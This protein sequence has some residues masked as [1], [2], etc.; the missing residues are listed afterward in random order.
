MA[1][2]LLLPGGTKV[3]G[4]TRR[5]RRSRQTAKSLSVWLEMANTRSSRGKALS[6][7]KENLAPFREDIRDYVVREQAEMGARFGEMVGE[8][9]RMGV[10]PGGTEMD[11]PVAG[12]EG[13]GLGLFQG[14]G[15]GGLRGFGGRA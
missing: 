11:Q 10:L 15:A 13:D 5:L 1:V 3:R 7:H 6:S 12:G 14:G 2:A 4:G 9:G 8:G